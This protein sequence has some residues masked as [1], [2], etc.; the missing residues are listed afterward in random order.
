M[1]KGSINI[2]NTK[3]V[4]IGGS[5]FRDPLFIGADGTDIHTGDTIEFYPEGNLF[6]S[7]GTVSNHNGL[8]A[9]VF[10]SMLNKWQYYELEI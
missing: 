4:N 9:D 2:K 7:Y 3:L 1:K 6:P 5:V 8:R 10:N